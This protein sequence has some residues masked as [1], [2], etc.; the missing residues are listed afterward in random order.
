MLKHTTLVLLLV[1][2]LI[3]N[4]NGMTI[5][6]NY[7][8]TEIGNTWVLDS[9]DKAERITYTIET[10]DETINDIELL[11]IRTVTETLGT[12][13]AMSQD[14]LVDIKEEGIY[15]YKYVVEVDDIFGV[16]TALLYP[17]QLFYPTSLTVGDTWQISVES[18]LNIIGPFT[19]LST[20]EVIAVEEVVTPIGTFEGC[21]KIRIRTRTI[22]A[23]GIT[24][25]TAYQWLAP[26]FGP[27][28]YE[29]SQDIVYELISSNLLYDT[30][31]DGN[32]NIL[33]LVFV[34]THFGEEN[35]LADVNRDGEVNILDLVL[36]AQNF[37]E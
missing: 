31:R 27:V 1:V 13:V 3:F 26:D 30:N 33:D 5:A 4:L 7:F 35:A 32:I 21:L 15:V 10:S 36:V 20:N 25:A 37:D 18:E 16:A 24:S 17:P 8:P 12:D 2:M 22:S 23:G 11:N 19:F 14:I 9:Q 28:K 34:S 6:Q 29:N